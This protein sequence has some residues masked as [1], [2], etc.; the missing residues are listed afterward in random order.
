MSKIFWDTNLFLYLVEASGER[1][2]LVVR[3]AER[4][5][6]RG[7]QLYTSTLTLG[8]VLMKP[9][10]KGDHALRQA[11]EDILLRNAVMIPFDESAARLYAQLRRDSSLRAAD[12]IQL[13]CAARAQVDMFITNDQRLAAKIVPGIHF[14]VSLK[15]AFL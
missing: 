7:D 8:E 12:V 6:E 13:S 3:L 10:E 15:E 5:L 4:M 9:S 2:K 14:I 1:S 11:Y